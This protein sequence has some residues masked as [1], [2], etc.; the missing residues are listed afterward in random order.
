MNSFLASS[1]STFYKFRERKF[2]YD[3]KYKYIPKEYLQAPLIMFLDLIWLPRGFTGRNKCFIPNGNSCS[4]HFNASSK[5]YQSWI[6]TYSL[7]SLRDKKFNDEGDTIR[8]FSEAAIKDQEAWLITYGCTHYQT[9]LI[10]K[11]LEFVQRKEVNGFEQIIYKGE[12]FSGLDNSRHNFKLHFPSH[13][14]SLAAAAFYNNLLMNLSLLTPSKNLCV[15]KD[16]IRL[17]G[18]FSV[19]KVSKRKYLVT[20]CCGAKS[21]EEE[22]KKELRKVIQNIEISKVM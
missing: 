10:L 19:I 16:R 18:Y 8:Y 1:F 17:F 4:D 22:V 12:M 20:Y 11:S 3:I 21:N 9:R 2:G 13:R 6:G 15:S 5:Y 14:F 7:K